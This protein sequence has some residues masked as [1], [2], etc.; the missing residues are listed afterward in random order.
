LAKKNG[1]LLD[2][3]FDKHIPFEQ[4]M[5]MLV[6][7]I[8]EKIDIFRILCKKYNCEFSCG[9]FIYFDNGESIPGLHL[10]SRYNRLVKELDID[11]DV[12]IYC[13][14]NE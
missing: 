9:L 13:L 14:P 4:Q 1:W 6:D 8:E 2:A 7:F 11:F 10:G 12:D 3:S 5:D